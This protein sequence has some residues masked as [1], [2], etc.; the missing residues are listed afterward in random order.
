MAPLATVIK[1]GVR[2]TEAK[3]IWSFDDKR[4]TFIP[5]T[6]TQDGLK[7]RGEPTEKRRKWELSQRLE[8]NNFCY[9]YVNTGCRE[10]SD[11]LHFLP[12]KSFSPPTL[13]ISCSPQMTN[14]RVPQGFKEVEQDQSHPIRSDCVFLLCHPQQQSYGIEVRGQGVPEDCSW[15]LA[16]ALGCLATGT[17]RLHTHA[18]THT[19]THTHT[20]MPGF[21]LTQINKSCLLEM[22]FKCNWFA[23]EHLFCR[24]HNID[25]S[26]S[27]LCGVSLFSPC[28]RGFSLASFNN[29][30]TC[31]LGLA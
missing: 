19:H 12:M 29:P 27:L 17:A 13:C 2:C 10:P 7:G 11:V 15:P 21:R 23:T 6:R 1:Q 4:T 16:P 8:N 20:N 31:R 3:L 30:N 28:L 5:P 24:K 9:I 22:T 18:C 25:Q 14:I 26:G